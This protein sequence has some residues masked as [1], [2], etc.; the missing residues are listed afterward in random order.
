MTNVEKQEQLNKL[1]TEKMSLESQLNDSDY[2]VI[3][4]AEC[5]AADLPLPYDIEA[6]HAERQ[7]KRYRINQIEDEIKITEETET[8]EDI[9]SEVEAE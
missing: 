8:E 5:K 6:L 2:K 3:K 9:M 7:L 4:C 1:Y